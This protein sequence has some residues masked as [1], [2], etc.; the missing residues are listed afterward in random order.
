MC[1]FDRGDDLGVFGPRGIVLAGWRVRGMLDVATVQLALDDVV[2]RH[3]ALRTT[4]IRD[5]DAPYARVSPP[6][7]AALTVVDLPPA[8]TEADRDRLAH[9]FL[10]EVDR[11]GRLGATEL[12]DVRRQ[13]QAWDRAS[14]AAL[15]AGDIERFAREYHEHGRVVVAPAPGRLGRARVR[16]GSRMDRHHGPTSSSGRDHQQVD[17]YGAAATSSADLSRGT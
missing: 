7:P 10:D 1:A 8:A 3:E 11:D 13:R 5:K 14:L 4:I 15:R 17:T 12:H 6:C 2:A 16:R 9:E